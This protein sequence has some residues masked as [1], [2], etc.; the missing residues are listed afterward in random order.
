MQDQAFKVLGIQPTEDGRAIRAAF[1]RLARIYHPD[2]FVDQPDD[3]R[4][5]AERRMKEATIAYETLR[6]T[7]REDRVVVDSISD[8]ELR[9]RTEKYRRAME[10]RRKEEELDRAK[11]QRW[12]AIERQAR[13]RAEIDARIAAMIQGE[14]EAPVAAARPR[15]QATPIKMPPSRNGSLLAERLDSARRGETA[16]L[17]RRASVDEPDAHAS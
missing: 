5:E 10:A 11:W 15:P 1:V 13:E 12:E 9:D 4:T 6:E 2:R 14:A 8:S 17:V 16:P 7:K 3:V